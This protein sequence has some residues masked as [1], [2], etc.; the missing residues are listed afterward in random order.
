MT[1]SDY[2]LIKQGDECG[3]LAD[4]GNPALEVQY[5]FSNFSF[6]VIPMMPDVIFCEYNSAY[7]VKTIAFCCMNNYQ[8]VVESKKKLSSSSWL[9]LQ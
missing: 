4:F 1:S 9:L 5:S 6:K 7:N 3:S 2:I 8:V